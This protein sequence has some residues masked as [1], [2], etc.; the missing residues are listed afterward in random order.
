MPKITELYAWVLADSGPDDEGVPAFMSLEGTWLPMMGA[1]LDRAI[2]LR[3][4][5]QWAANLSGKQV[6]LLRSVGTLEEVEV[7]QPNQSARAD[8]EGE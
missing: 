6:R 8:S 3:P 7:V 4:H 2:S 1:D 5:A